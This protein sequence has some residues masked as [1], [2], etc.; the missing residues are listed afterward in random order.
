[1]RSVRAVSPHSPFHPTIW[2]AAVASVRSP[3]YHRAKK[4]GGGREGERETVVCWDVQASFYQRALFL[5][6]TRLEWR[7]WVGLAPALLAEQQR[8]QEVSELLHS[9]PP[10]AHRSSEQCTCTSIS[11]ENAPLPCKASIRTIRQ[12]TPGKSR[13]SLSRVKATFSEGGSSWRRR[14]TAHG[15]PGASMTRMT[16]VP[17]SCAPRHTHRFNG[18]VESASDMAT[19]TPPR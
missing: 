12:A 3:C 17:S 1:M 18:S 13:T 6:V 14:H 9:A 5:L 19:R 16:G 2:H 15:P 11:D 10:R 8:R 7:L 4:R